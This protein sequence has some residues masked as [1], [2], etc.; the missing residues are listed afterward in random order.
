MKNKLNIVLAIVLL[1]SI[2][3]GI[4]SIFYVSKDA[5]SYIKIKDEIIYVEVAD[6]PELR[7]QGLSNRPKLEEGWGML[8]TFPEGYNSAFVMRD[9]LFSL[10]I[11]WI[12]DQ[13]I[14]KIDK[15]LP[16]PYETNNIPAMA[17]SPGT[18]HYVLEITGGVSE[19]KKIAVGD[20]VEI[21]I[22]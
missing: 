3:L 9:M 11:I 1:V 15:N 17:Y 2:I 13:K 12:K 8:F 18:I 20:D 7:Y 5:K 22:Y 10:D 14:V 4:G 16:P 19:A 21:V 6:T